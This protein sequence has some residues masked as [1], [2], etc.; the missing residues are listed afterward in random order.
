[1]RIGE[2]MKTNIVTIDENGT[3][4]E[5]CTLMGENR[6]GSLV[7]TRDGKPVGIF[8]ERDFLSKVVCAGADACKLK[9]SEYMSEPLITVNQRFTVREAARIMKDMKIKRLLVA[10]GEEIV[11][12]FTAADL[13]EVIAETPFDF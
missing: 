11:G 13:V 6:I 10:D 8:T 4:D 7:V 12:I 2:V 5:A 3:I 1:M 9:V